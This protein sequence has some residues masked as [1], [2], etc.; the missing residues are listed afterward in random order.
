MKAFLF[1]IVCLLCLWLPPLWPVW[2]FGWLCYA[3]FA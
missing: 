3:V 2:V 1:F